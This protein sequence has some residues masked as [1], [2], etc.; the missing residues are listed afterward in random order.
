MERAR[1]GGGVNNCR[2]WPEGHLSAISGSDNG[3]F[4]ANLP[5]GCKILFLGSEPQV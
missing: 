4:A 1:D 2:Q 5:S 3:H